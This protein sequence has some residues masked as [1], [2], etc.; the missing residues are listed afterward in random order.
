MP[1][2]HLQSRE[3]RREHRKRRLRRHGRRAYIRSAYSLPSLATLGN[4]ICGFGAMYVATLSREMGQESPDPLTQWFYKYH[5]FVSAYLIFVA[6]LF[7]ALDGRLARFTRHTTDFGGQLDSLADVISFG[8][9]PAFL[10][11]QVFK[12]DHFQDV[13]PVV[14]RLVW[15]MGALY[16]SCA[17]IRLARFNVSNEHGEQHHFSFLGLPSPGAGGAVAALVLMQQDMR[18]QAFAPPYG[19]GTTIGEIFWNLSNVCV[20]LLPL[21][22][23]CTGLLM[24]SGIRYPHIV[25]RYLRGKRSLQRLLLMLVLLLAI[26][27]AH[28]YVLGVGCLAYALSGVLSWGYLR[29]RHMTG[30]RVAP[31]PAGPAPAAGANGPVE[32]NPLPRSPRAT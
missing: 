19:R 22:V 2:T 14:S 28:R 32:P 15:A 30:L 31:A 1:L 13:A 4:A 20:W 8:A 5:F 18:E 6:M 11:L 29:L 23:L 3:H 21:V 16:M 24:V 25:N 27:V 7:D 26:F 12:T 10:A 17:A 9:A